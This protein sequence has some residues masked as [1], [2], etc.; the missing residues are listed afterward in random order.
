MIRR[1]LGIVG[2]V[3]LTACVSNGLV[4]D[5][6]RDAS[7]AKNPPVRRPTSIAQSSPTTPSA[8]G[9][10][11]GSNNQRGKRLPSDVSEYKGPIRFT[12]TP[13]K[14][15]FVL[16]ENKMEN[17]PL[18]TSPSSP[19]NA[20]GWKISN[21]GQPD[22]FLYGITCVYAAN[23]MQKDIRFFITPRPALPAD[24][25]D[26]ANNVSSNIFA[27][28]TVDQ[29]PPTWGEALRVAFGDEEYAKLKRDRDA[30]VAVRAIE[31]DRDQ[32]ARA[33]NARKEEVARKERERLAAIERANRDAAQKERDK[34]VVEGYR[35]NKAS[36]APPSTANIAEVV[37]AKVATKSSRNYDGITVDG[38]KMTMYSTTVLG[39]IKTLEA[40]PIIG[41]LTCAASGPSMQKCSW[42][43]VWVFKKFLF[44]EEYG[45]EWTEDAVKEAAS[46]TWSDR[47][48]TSSDYDGSEIRPPSKNSASTSSGPSD[49]E[50]QMKEIREQRES[51]FRRESQERF[52]RQQQRQ[53]C[54]MSNGMNC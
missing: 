32:K 18:S 27:D 16:F 50:R 28:V 13:K 51:D 38:D 22:R 39:N 48:L 6:L 23:G 34:Q 1:C 20:A 42:S 29:C 21:P 17:L 40:R 52:E 47:G 41:N 53:N 44:G 9:D 31:A 24:V 46:F 35:R 43:V 15:R 37:T 3:S 49:G 8:T 5:A 30:T 11:N 12:L 45:N 2:A 26:T 14:G 33:E 54:R 4:P 7:E 36:N 10:I 19:W 25:V